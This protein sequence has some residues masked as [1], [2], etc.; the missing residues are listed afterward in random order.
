MSLIGKDNEDKIWN[1]L[2]SKGLNDYG[3]AGTMGNLFW[4]SGL[5][6]N[7]LENIG[8]TRLGMTDDE[9]TEAVD[10][11]TYT[12]SQFIN[13]GFGFSLAQWTYPTR[14]K[15]LYE[16]AKSNGKSIGDLE[17]ALEYLYKELSRDYPS[18]LNVLKNATS[19]LEA[20]NVVLLKFERPAD[21]S[22]SMQNKRAG[23][24]QKYYDKYA[25][26]KT[27]NNDN[28]DDDM[29]YTKGKST[30]L[31]TNFKSAEF[32]CH[33]KGCCS[34]TEVDAK[35]VNYLQKIRDH[36]GKSVTI[37]SGYRCSRHNKNVGGATGSYHT[38]GKA[39]D[40][41]IKGVAPAEIAKYAESIGVLGIGLYETAKDGYFVH[42]DTRT[43][44]YFWYGQAG[45]Y[46][47]TFGGKSTSSAP[48]SASSPTKLKRGD[49]G[50]GVRDLQKKLIAL[51]YSCG[52]KGADGKFGAST[53]TAVRQFQKD[54]GLEVDGIVGKDTLNALKIKVKVTASVLNVRAGAGTNYSVITTVKKDSV[55]ELLDEK[56]GWGKISKGW[57]S[58]T[59]YK[60]L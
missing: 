15:A 11:G 41:Y 25:S 56:N 5:R 13:D 50:E 9:Y 30:K 39:A 40:I 33:G 37:S 45:A 42:I 8:N 53:E 48:S 1:F 43:S 16:C 57:I 44:K 2:K 32:D 26:N 46:R 7:N 51:G 18:V 29:S 60:K 21:Q 47:S 3:I 23:Y 59:Y 19:V 4:E 22:I 14:K 49:S 10:N 34:S 31:S 38:K 6:S 20:S 36:F 24:G 12:K 58:S 17:V 28:G 27:I 52:S 35:L 55:H 54:K